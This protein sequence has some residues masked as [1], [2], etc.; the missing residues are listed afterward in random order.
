MTRRI[1]KLVISAAF[2]ACS[3]A[4]QVVLKVFGRPIPGR[5]VVLYYHVV[6]PEERE[7]FARQMD[8]LLALAQPIS[9]EN[10]PE[11][12][13]GVHY[14]AVTFDD[15]F[16]ETIESV[17]PEMK[18][19]NIPITVFLPT[20][21]LGAEPPWISDRPSHH[22]GGGILA[23]D[24]IRKID[25]EPLVSFGSHCIMH[26]PL[27]T[28]SDDEARDE[29]FRSKADLEKALGHGVESLSFP[30][31]AF[32][33]RHV[34]WAREAGYRRVYSIE[35]SAALLHPDEFVTGRFR[36]DS[37]DWRMEFQLKI[38]GSY[39]WLSLMK[40]GRMNA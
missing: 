24:E 35:S 9:I 34:D 32:G 6:R 3:A 8:I 13:P 5:C 14:A 18:K 17:L 26:R 38:L 16:R 29:I 21:C 2:W 25:A 7:R 15:G 33:Q 20:G 28:L 11:L 37:T 19:R 22:Y 36:V 31:G 12:T 39:R 40:R 1:I 27:P 10:P 23:E 4:W 30:H